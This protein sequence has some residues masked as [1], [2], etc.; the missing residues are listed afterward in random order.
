ML[1]THLGEVQQSLYL[2][3]QAALA[4]PQLHRRNMH[5]TAAAA[6]ALMLSL[7]SYYET[8]NP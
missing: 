4:H 2:P 6:A 3:Q 1:Q 5:L 7:S 8:P